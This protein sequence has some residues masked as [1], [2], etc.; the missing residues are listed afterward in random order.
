VLTEAA[1]L[2]SALGRGTAAGLQFNLVVAALTAALAAGV[3]GYRRAPR[4]RVWWSAAILVAGW[5]LGEGARLAAAGTGARAVGWALAGL[6]AGYI[7]PAVTGA[8]IG[9]LVHKGTGYLSAAVVALTMVPAL[10][11]VG[12]SVGGLLARALA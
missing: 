12:H 11:S 4:S 8:Y 2:L 10:A 1:T 9:R 5:L 6:A 7:L 3:S